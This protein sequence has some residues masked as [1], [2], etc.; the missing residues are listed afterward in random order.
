MLQG[1]L[2]M[3]LLIKAW[4]I[5]EGSLGMWASFVARLIIYLIH[6]TKAEEISETVLLH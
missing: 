2:S 1:M 4:N 5:L 3:D 6:E